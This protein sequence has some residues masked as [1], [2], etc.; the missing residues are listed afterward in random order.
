MKTKIWIFLLTIALAGFTN[1]KTKAQE[2]PKVKGMTFEQTVNYYKFWTKTMYPWQRSLVFQHWKEADIKFVEKLPDF[3]LRLK[4]DM[5]SHPAYFKLY[6]K[7]LEGIIQSQSV[8]KK[9]Y[10]T[11]TDFVIAGDND[12]PPADGKD[13]LDF[14]KR[15]CYWRKL[16]NDK[17]IDVLNIAAN[18]LVAAEKSGND[19]KMKFAL[20]Y[21]K[22]IKIIYPNNPKS[23]L[24]VKRAEK[25]SSESANSGSILSKTKTYK[26]MEKQM[27]GWQ[28]SLVRLSWTEDV[29]SDIEKYPA[30]EAMMKK[31]V[32]AH[33]KF[34][35]LYPKQL[36]NK[37]GMGTI[38]KNNFDEFTSYRLAGEDEDPPANSNDIKDFY[39]RYCYWRNIM[40]KDVSKVMSEATKVIAKAAEAK[41]Q[42]K[43]DM[44]KFAIRYCKAVKIMY[45]ENPMS[46]DL[47]AR[48]EATLLKS[49]DDVRHLLSGK[50]HKAHYKE[51][52][53]YNE[54]PII[55]KENE[56]AIT[57]E[58][59][60]G[61]PFYFVGYFADKIDK[62]KINAY[63]KGKPV[64]ATPTLGW[65]LVGDKH[66]VY[67]GQATYWDWDIIKIVKEQTYFVF[68]LFPKIEEINYKSHI[69]YIPIL[70]IITWLTYQMPGEY[71]FEFSLSGGAVGTFKIKL[72]KESIAEL[73]KYQEQLKAKKLEAV[74]FNGENGCDNS[75]TAQLGGV[76]NMR[77]HGE[78]IRFTIAQTGQVMMPWPNN[79]QV[80]NYVG[81][82]WGV[83]KQPNGKYEIISLGFSRAAS[84]NLWSFTSCNTSS[85]YELK[86]S[87]PI[88]PEILKLGYEILEKNI[89]KCVKW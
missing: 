88:K 65:H 82:G 68:N 44:S 35:R 86:G 15:Y 54:K 56:A 4:T 13:Y 16:M 47:I 49:W 30:F 2:D 36:K 5:A 29:I 10:R 70:N 63:Y 75:S 25:S 19:E 20:R 3:E 18:N 57:N 26:N 60:P 17:A 84:S 41:L 77:K 72:T 78:I 32:A 51:L 46:N 31:D 43:I 73:K 83:F 59:I 81:S 8:D 7:Q 6:P 12:N 66:G 40:D 14:Y 79:K 58:I 62:L 45:P 50:M 67:G 9:N 21:C 37:S 48:A 23:D 53:G 74:S 87:I 34:F 61:K 80:K 89:N 22:A 28:N 71:E 11:F 85:D 39:I 24:L 1:V 69:Q 42:D 27:S 33:P 38:T 55:G 76:E 52:V 64:T